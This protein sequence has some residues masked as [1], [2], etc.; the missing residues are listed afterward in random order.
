MLLVALAVC[1]V[2]GVCDGEDKL[3]MNYYH[4]TCP[5]AETIVRDMTWSKVAANSVLP[6]KLLRLHFHDC[7]VRVSFLYHMID[8]PSIYEF[9]YVVAYICMLQGCDASVLL[10]STTNTTAEKDASPNLSLSGYDVIDDIK[11]RLEEECPEI[12]SC[13]DI[14]TLAARDAVSYQVSSDLNQN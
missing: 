6:A 10:D 13:A 5:S 8:F 7:F 2:F 14:L 3:K 4:K 9:N 1:A 11:A 12:V